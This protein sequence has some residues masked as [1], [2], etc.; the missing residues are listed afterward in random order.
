[1][2]QYKMKYAASWE[3]FTLTIGSNVSKSVLPAIGL[4]WS[5]KSDALILAC[6]SSNNPLRIVAVLM[7]IFSSKKRH[8]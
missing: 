4:K 8:S 6:N 2:P 5:K 3:F 7:N 1:M